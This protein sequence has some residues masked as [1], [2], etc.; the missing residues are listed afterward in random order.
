MEYVNDTRHIGYFVKGRIAE[1]LFELMFREDPGRTFTII[2]FGYE[3]TTPELAQ[4]SDLVKNYQ[5]LKVIKQSPDFILIKNDKSKVYFVEVKY[6][7]LFNSY[8][9]KDLSIRAAELSKYW[10][11]TYYFL[12]TQEG[13]YFDSC[14]NIVKNFG[15][16]EKLNEKIIFPEIQAKYLAVLKEFVR[17]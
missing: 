1:L 9:K 7:K 3:K 4:Y 8:V 2:P 5:T 17:I 13:F 10:T 6:R 15:G 16:M 11:E 14:H 12:A